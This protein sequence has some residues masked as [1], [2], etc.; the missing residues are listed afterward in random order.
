MYRNGVVPD[1]VW[2]SWRWGV[3]RRPE[4][5]QHG[6]LRGCRPQPPAA[7]Q[8]D[9]IGPATQQ[10]RGLW[11]PGRRSSCRTSV[12]NAHRYTRCIVRSD[13]GAIRKEGR[14]RDREGRGVGGR[15]A[16]EG[17]GEGDPTPAK[18]A[19]EREGPPLP[20]FD[21]P[22]RALLPRCACGG[23]TGQ[24]LGTSGGPPGDTNESVM[25]HVSAKS[26]NRTVAEGSSAGVGAG[27]D[28]H[29]V[30]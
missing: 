7:L 22:V 12:Q 25:K 30:C 10:Q 17:K 28:P 15:G 18:K 6:L 3:I 29:G 4:N 8:A 1:D 13:D 27:A 21:P 9:S 24:T 5:T 19:G 20:S 11:A 16:G 26:D 14:G 2:Y 23:R